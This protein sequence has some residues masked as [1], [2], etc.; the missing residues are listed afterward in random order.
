MF[1]LGVL[2][3]GSFFLA[4]TAGDE[5]CHGF[6]G[7]SWACPDSHFPPEF[8]KC[9]RR[10]ETWQCC[11]PFQ[12]NEYDTFVMAIS[13]F[14]IAV[15]LLLSVFFVICCFWSPCPLYSVCRINYTYGDIIAYSKEDEAMSLPPEASG[16]HHYTPVHVKINPIEV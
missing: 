4:F 6:E 5:E 16:K 13:V 11:P 10:N 1:R 12:N 9:C 3:L 15:C 2:I 7:E 14:V 8:I